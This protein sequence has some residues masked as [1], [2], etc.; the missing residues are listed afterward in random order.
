MGRPRF[1]KPR[2][3]LAPRRIADKLQEL[4]DSVVDVQVPDF[5]SIEGILEQLP[6]G[7]WRVTPVL[8]YGLAELWFRAPDVVS[9]TPSAEVGDDDQPLQYTIEVRRQMTFTGR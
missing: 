8:A 9:L 6:R 2:R 3:I 7:L 5:A 4:E 1:R